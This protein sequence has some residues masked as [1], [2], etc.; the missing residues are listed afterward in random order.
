ML[1]LKFCGLVSLQILVEIY[2]KKI[3]KVAFGSQVSQL[4]LTD[5]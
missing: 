1:W 4:I 5:K 3:S 2:K